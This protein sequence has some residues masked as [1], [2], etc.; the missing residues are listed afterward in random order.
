MKNYDKNMESSYLMYLDANNLYGWPVSQ[1]LPVD[2]FKWIKKSFKFNEDFIKKYDENIYK[3]YFLEVDVEYPKNL[4]NLNS[5]L[6]FLPERLKTEKCNKL[7]CNVYDKKQ[8]L[9]HG[10]ILKKLHQVI[11]FT[12]KAWLKPY[13]DMNT[14]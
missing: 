9:S 14:K 4:Y 8:A 1:K 13:M 11:Q 2:G 6:P 5:D 10:L 7:V 12:Q 3:G